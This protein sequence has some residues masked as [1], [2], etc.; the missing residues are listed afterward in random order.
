MAAT[1]RD[2]SVE[3]RKK[4]T[5]PAEDSLPSICLLGSG[6]AAGEE[7]T[8]E[9]QR[10]APEM[11]RGQRLAEDDDGKTHPDEWLQ[12]AEDGALPRVESGQAVAAKN[13]GQSRAANPEV[14]EQQHVVDRQGANPPG[15]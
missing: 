11:A 12:I 13:E 2:K 3:R 1:G 10:A 6:I 15:G 7:H 14:K 5:A 4:I 8:K 9:Y